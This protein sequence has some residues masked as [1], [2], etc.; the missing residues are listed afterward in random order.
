M[1]YD[2]VLLS[3]LVCSLEEVVL[4]EGLSE[5]PVPSHTVWDAVVTSLLAYLSWDS[6]SHP[7]NKA[8]LI[9]GE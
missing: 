6:V 9:L 5:V 7:W 1:A 8:H 2:S 3:C 4:Q